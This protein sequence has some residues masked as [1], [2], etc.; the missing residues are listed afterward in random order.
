[1]G[2]THSNQTILEEIKTSEEENQNKNELTKN[3][4][5]ENAEDLMNKKEIQSLE[6]DFYDIVEKDK[7]NELIYN[8]S[9]KENDLIFKSKEINKQK[10]II[11]IEK[12]CN[13]KLGEQLEVLEN[14][15][16][17][18]DTSYK[19]LLEKYEKLEYKN[20]I[21]EN[22]FLSNEDELENYKNNY[23]IL[24]NEKKKMNDELNISIKNNNLK[25]NE[26]EILND[27]YNKLLIKYNNLNNNNDLYKIL[28]SKNIKLKLQDII[29]YTLK[30]R[31]INISR[32]SLE[33]I[34]NNLV[35]KLK[36]EIKIS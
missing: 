5:L 18:D 24:L 3:K 32:S 27:K 13:K 15:L 19:E 28:N 21:I 20:L 34:V 22:K 30:R 29:N 2:S 36:D 1:M 17:L 9:I 11:N 31:C 25:Q 26:L 10:Q 23:N 4:I 14:T 16:K 33:E 35:N 12:G 7:Y 8:L 6:K